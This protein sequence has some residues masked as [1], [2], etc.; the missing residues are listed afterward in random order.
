LKA[1]FEND[2]G[3]E[4]D[5][6]AEISEYIADPLAKGLSRAAAFAIL[7]V[8]LL[9]LLTMVLLLI[10]LVV[11]L[12]LLNGANKFLG[13]VFGVVMGLACAWGL[14]TV[15]CALMPHL[16]VIYEGV[17]PASV[18]ENTIVVKFLGS[19]DILGYI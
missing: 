6:E 3:A 2:L 1:Y 4:N 18:I 17:V 19:I 13:A 11:K 10:D 15:F 5:S 8:G 16:A 9:I 12:P 7:F 14:S